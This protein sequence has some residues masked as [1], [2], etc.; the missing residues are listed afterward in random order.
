[1]SIESFF[2]G[3]ALYFYLSRTVYFSVHFTLLA[4]GVSEVFSTFYDY[5]VIFLLC[6]NAERR[7]PV[8]GLCDCL[9]VSVG[10]GGRG[11]LY[12]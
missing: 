2:F 5:F 10:M 11:V 1:M 6:A 7:Q 12:N 3:S 8:G 4:A 9:L